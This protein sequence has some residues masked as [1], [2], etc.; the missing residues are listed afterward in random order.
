MSLEVMS[1]KTN[2]NYKL[3]ADC[4][5]VKKINA[6][7]KI[8][9]A[10]SS[11]KAELVHLG[12]LFTDNMSLAI[13]TAPMLLQQKIL[14]TKVS[15]VFKTTRKFEFNKNGF[16]FKDFN[17]SPLGKAIE[18]IAIG[19]P[20]WTDIPQ[21]TIDEHSTAVE[22]ALTNWA[23][24]IGMQFSKVVWI[25][26]VYRNTAAGKFGA[27]HFTHVDFPD[28]DH[29]ATLKGHDSWKERVVKK[30]GELTTEQYEDLPVKN[31]INMWMPL[32][33]KIEAEP[34]ALMDLQSLKNPTKDLRVYQDARISTG[35][36][37]P[38]VGILPSDG[39]RWYIRDGM[40]RGEAVIFDCCKT[41]HSAVS[42]PDQGTK[43]RRS[44]ES[45]VLFLE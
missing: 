32:D 29:K 2:N 12:P 45:R 43:G 19:P 10:E 1:C 16:E 26:T 11:F 22:N 6:R 13:E 36:A 38:S 8:T 39:Q 27:V 4:S 31:I 34:L 28:G 24:G 21:S 33:E 30:L 7:Q 9:I 40:K 18:K 17:N 37:Y 42:L 3:H 25:D 14:Q 15:R 35:T 41:P 20:V 5:T 23:K 44:L